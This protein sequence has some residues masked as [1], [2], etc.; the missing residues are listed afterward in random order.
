[1]NEDMLDEIKL[2]FNHFLIKNNFNGDVAY[3]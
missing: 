2:S 1:M 3:A